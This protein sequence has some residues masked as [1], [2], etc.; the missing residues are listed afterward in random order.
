MRKWWNTDVTVM[1]KD[2]FVPFF[3]PHPI[4]EINRMEVSKVQLESWYVAMAKLH[5]LPTP[6]TID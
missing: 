1:S 2:T 6:P 3:V 4:F 5:N